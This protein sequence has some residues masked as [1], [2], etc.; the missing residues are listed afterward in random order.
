MFGMLIS[1]KR[2]AVSGSYIIEQDQKTNVTDVPTVNAKSKS[3][4]TKVSIT[5]TKS[6][7]KNQP[8]SRKFQFIY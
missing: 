5:T 8:F 1:D 3:W 6:Q 2:T 7:F 4:L